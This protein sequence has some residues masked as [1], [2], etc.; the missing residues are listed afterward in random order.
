[1]LDLER[2]IAAV[3]VKSVTFGGVRMSKAQRRKFAVDGA[4]TGQGRG[5]YKRFL[6]NPGGGRVAPKTQAKTAKEF[7]GRRRPPTAA[8]L[9]KAGVVTPNRAGLKRAD[10]LAARRQK[11]AGWL[12]NPKG[13]RP[14]PLAR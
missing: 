13:K 10:R 5:P 9:R 1:M 2:A 8:R 3:E 7:G 12:A 6:S 4:W 11:L 14:K